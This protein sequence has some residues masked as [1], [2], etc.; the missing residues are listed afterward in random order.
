MKKMLLKLANHLDKKGLYAEADAIDKIIHLAAPGAPPPPGAAPGAPAT[1]IDFKDD[2]SKLQGLMTQMN[3]ML[4]QPPGKVQVQQMHDLLKK[5]MLEFHS[6]I[7]KIESA[8]P[9]GQSQLNRQDQVMNQGK[10]A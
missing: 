2:R 4:N 9:A 10:N 3:S 8:N 7:S 1:P 6:I 5:M